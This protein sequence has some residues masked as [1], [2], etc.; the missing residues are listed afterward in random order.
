MNNMWRSVAR[1]ARQ[2]LLWYIRLL[3]LVKL[4]LHQLASAEFDKLGDLHRP[5]LTAEY[6]PQLYPGR[7]G[8]LVPFELWMLWACLPAWLKY[9][10]LS[11]ERITLLSVDCKKMQS[12]DP[13][14]QGV[15]RQRE[16]QVYL[17]LSTQ[18]MAM[19][20][21]S[22]AA[23]MMEMVLE[24]FA[25]RDGKQN[26]DILSGLGRLYLQLGDYASA[27]KMYQRIQEQEKHENDASVQEAILTN[28]AFLYM[29]DGEWLKAKHLL[30][31]VYEANNDNL[32]IVSNLA[33]CEVYL[34]QLANAIELLEKLTRENPSSAGTCETVLMNLCTLYEVRYDSAV[35]KKI[36]VLKQVA[37]WVGDSFNAECIKLQ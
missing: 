31:Q 16:M 33:V 29:A 27:E 13:E 36:D 32:L 17:V 3:A 24:H 8:T 28:K 19:Q 18:L 22:T 25:T 37:R 4:G 10:L 6:H 14:K 35:E 5:E 20:D 21:F 15:W 26:I 9:P 12:R 34:G 30:Q 7:I 2:R 1:Y 23:S 11:L